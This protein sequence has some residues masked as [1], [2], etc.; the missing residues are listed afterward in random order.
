MVADAVLKIQ[1]MHPVNA[2]QQDM[3]YFQISLV[4][5]VIVTVVAVTPVLRVCG[6]IKE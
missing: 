1:R 2:D 6:E 3:F 4:V 5:A